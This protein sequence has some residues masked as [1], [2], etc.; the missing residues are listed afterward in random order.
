MNEPA[1]L[2]VAAAALAAQL[3]DV[4][5]VRVHD[6]AGFGDPTRRVAAVYTDGGQL[7][8]VL[9]P[10]GSRDH[11]HADEEVVIVDK[12]GAVSL[13]FAP[14]ADELAR[15]TLERALEY[16]HSAWW[17]LRD[18]AKYLRRRSWYEAVERLAVARDYMLRLVA[19]GAEARFPQ[20]GLMSLVDFSPEAIPSRLADT[21]PSPG[22]P[23]AILAAAFVVADLIDTALRE[24]NR[25]VGRPLGTALADDVRARLTAVVL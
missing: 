20:Y 24:T 15:R 25:V 21:Y 11:H 1:S 12:D 10:V 14:P 6:H 17:F 3:G 19:I 18:V 4:V 22:E 9:F 8:L 13:P 23:G 7:D 2:E 16:E 5:D